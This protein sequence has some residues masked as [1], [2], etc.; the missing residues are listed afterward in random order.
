M[1]SSIETGRLVLR[2]FTDGDVERLVALDS[3]PE[4]MR[5][6]TN[7]RATPRQLIESDILPAFTRVDRRYPAAGFWAVIEGAT[8]EFVGW[9]GLQVCAGCSG[10]DAE[11]GY[12]LRR[13]SWGKGY[14]TESARALIGLVFAAPGIERVFAT[15]FEE[16]LASRRV[17]EKLGMRL[18][19]RFRVTREQLAEASTFDATGLEPFRGEDVEYELDR[20]IWGQKQGCTLNEH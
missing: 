13:S 12:R 19:R 11:L 16:N 1:R 3:D 8:G 2:R 14:A 6:L 17:M 15:A 7:G 20:A 9:V 4:V 10:A 18:A 5:F